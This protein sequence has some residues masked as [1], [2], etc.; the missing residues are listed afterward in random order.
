MGQQVLWTGGAVWPANYNK[1]D[2]DCSQHTLIG[3]R[4]REPGPRTKA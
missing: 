4:M 2:K 1:L 3:M